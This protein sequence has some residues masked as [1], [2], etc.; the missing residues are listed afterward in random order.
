MQNL[1]DATNPEAVTHKEINVPDV[2]DPNGSESLSLHKYFHLR[3]MPLPRIL[4][5]LLGRIQKLLSF[6][7]CSM[8]LQLRLVSCSQDAR[9]TEQK[10]EKGA[11]S[12]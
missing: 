7:R 8:V 6:R 2:L 9:A 3:K 1:E 4:Q 10:G 12:S 5:T 11:L